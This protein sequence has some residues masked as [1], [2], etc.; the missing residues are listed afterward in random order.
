MSKPPLNPLEIFLLEFNIETT[1]PTEIFIPENLKFLNRS[2]SNFLHVAVENDLMELIPDAML[3]QEYLTIQ[4]GN[5]LTPFHIAATTCYLTRLLERN[6]ELTKRPLYTQK[7]KSGMTPFLA[8]CLSETSLDAYPKKY[9]LPQDFEVENSLGETAL[10]IIATELPEKTLPPEWLTLKRLLKGNI[11]DELPAHNAVATTAKT[12][13][14]H[15]FTPEVATYLPKNV[16]PTI[17]DYV[18]KNGLP[19]LLKNAPANIQQSVMIKM[20]DNHKEVITFGID[21][22]NHKEW[23]KMCPNNERLIEI[24]NFLKR[25]SKQTINPTE[26]IE[27]RE[28]LNTLARTVEVLKNIQTKT[29]Q[30]NSALN[31]IKD[32]TKKPPSQATEV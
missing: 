5:Y 13:I 27:L 10:H 16:A 3:Q 14:W 21:R 26:T 25:K 31:T 12:N 8:A 22:I 4:N 18:H 23:L 1:N 32:A 30:I 29:K 7:N 11:A 20:L 15:W 17:L 24:T 2:K 19:A 28:A 6:T 9:L